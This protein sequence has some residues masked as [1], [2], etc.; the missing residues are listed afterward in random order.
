MTKLCHWCIIT[1]GFSS[2]GSERAHP[3][4]NAFTAILFILLRR[5]SGRSPANSLTAFAQTVP[6]TCQL[7][8]QNGQNCLP[9]AFIHGRAISTVLDMSHKKCRTYVQSPSYMKTAYWFAPTFFIA[10]NV[11]SRRYTWQNKH[12]LKIREW[13]SIASERR[14][15]VWARSTCEF[16]SQFWQ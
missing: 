6:P 11:E 12:L 4:I 2:I 8:S 1:L 9:N 16:G 3:C 13:A 15:T 5:R 10:N 14:T 7:C